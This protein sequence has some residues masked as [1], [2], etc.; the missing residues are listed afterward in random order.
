[1]NCDVTPM[2]G[3]LPVGLSLLVI[4]SAQ[5]TATADVRL[6]LERCMSSSP[7]HNC[8]AGGSFFLE[9]DEADAQ[10]AQAARDEEGPSVPYSQ[11]RRELGL[12]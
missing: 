8:S 10:L 1:M 5:P 2:N 11:A 12:E 4:C 7:H 9:E 3:Y 6:W